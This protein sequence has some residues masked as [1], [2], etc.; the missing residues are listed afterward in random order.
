VISF[1]DVKTIATI[2]LG[3]IAAVGSVLM[4]RNR[5]RRK[6]ERDRSR[7]GVAKAYDASEASLLDRL[8]R[9]AEENQDRADKASQER[10]DV[11][12][13]AAGMAQEIDSLRRDTERLERHNQQCEA[14]IATLESDLRA[15][16]D[17]IHS[18]QQVIDRRLKPR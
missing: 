13:K 8:Q 17:R 16:F 12:V 9:M 3:T 11:A 7:D 5:L 14:R 10:Y 15:A 1:E 2:L 18:M 4:G 6:V